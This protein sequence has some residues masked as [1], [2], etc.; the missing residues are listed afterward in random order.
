MNIN[1]IITLLVMIFMIVSFVIQKW[2]Y[3]LTDVYKKQS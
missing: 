3:G 1:L 2:S